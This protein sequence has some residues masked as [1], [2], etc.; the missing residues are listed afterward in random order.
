VL[1]SDFHGETV[2]TV[3]VTDDRHIPISLGRG[4]PGIE[5]SSARYEAGL[6]E[7]PASWPTA[8][9]CLR[10]PAWLDGRQATL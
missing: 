10:E 7:Q 1:R 2:S 8:L 5:S 6:R 4:G 3:T 9:P